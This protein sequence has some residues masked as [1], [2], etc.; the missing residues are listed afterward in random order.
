MV[1]TA[2]AVFVFS[3]RADYAAV[4]S[5]MALWKVRP[6]TWEVDG[7]AG[8]ITLR[9]APVAVFDDESGMGGQFKRAGWGASKIGVPRRSRFCEQLGAE[10]S[11]IGWTAAVKGRP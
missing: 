8:Q 10:M 3:R 1:A 7:V 9:P 2:A 4:I 11:C 5:R 6:R